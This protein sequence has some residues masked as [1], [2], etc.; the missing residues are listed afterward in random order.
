MNRIQNTFFFLLFFSTSISL[1]SQQCS[2][3]SLTLVSPGDVSYTQPGFIDPNYLPCVSSGTYSELVIPFKTY[4]QGAR[5]L[6]NAD[7]STVPI[8]RIYS[9]KIESVS[10]LP[11]GLCWVTRPSTSVISGEQVGLLIIKGTTSVSSGTYPVSV[12]ISID[13]QGTGNYTSTGLVPF[14]YKDLLGQVILKVMGTDNNCP[15]VN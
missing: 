14:N 5:L 6:T 7:S 8:S 11:S 13:T 3:D 9:I 4:N 10:N 12:G 2:S 15:S 1:F